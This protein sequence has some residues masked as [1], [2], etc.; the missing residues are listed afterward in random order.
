[1]SGTDGVAEH[2]HFFR[3]NAK[4]LL[5]HRLLP[6]RDADNAVPH[7]DD[8]RIRQRLHCRLIVSV[9]SPQDKRSAEGKALPN[10][11]DNI[12]RPIEDDNNRLLGGENV[13][14]KIVEGTAIDASYISRL[15][16]AGDGHYLMAAADQRGCQ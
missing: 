9:L 11:P 3:G 5:K 15:V 6:V 16:N 4:H 8:G 12:A 2:V 13:N 14:G 10:V 7:G 1:E